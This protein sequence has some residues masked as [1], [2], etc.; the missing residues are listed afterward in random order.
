MARPIK[1]LL[2]DGE[3]LMELRRRARSPTV[4]VRDSER[5]IEAYLEA[6]NANPTPYTWRAEGAKILAKI[7]RARAALDR[8]V[9]A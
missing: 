3:A 8:E 6:R 4:A 7:K 2:A 5:D 9:A 1:R